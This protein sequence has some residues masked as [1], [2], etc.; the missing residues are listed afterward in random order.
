MQIRAPR[1]ITETAASAG[2][3]K[4]S[5]TVNN[6]ARLLTAACLAGAYIAL[7]GILSLIVGF[8]FPEITASN[9]AMQKLLSGC[10]FPIGL[11]LVVVLGAELFTGNNALLIPSYM[12]REHSFGTVVRNWTLVYIGNFIGAVLFTYLMVYRHSRGK[13]VYAVDD[14]AAQGDRS[15]LVCL[16]RCMARPSR[17]NIF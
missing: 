8:G 17:K 13:G 5:L 3:A 7:G 12:K 15:Q 2:A 10:M 6:T 4:A 14:R 16:P 1:E 9:P 11:I